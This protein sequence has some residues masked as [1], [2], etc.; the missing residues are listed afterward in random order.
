MLRLAA[1]SG[2][3]SYDCEYVAVAEELGCRLATYDRKVIRRFP[4]IAVTPETLLAELR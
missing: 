1:E 3:S 2:C 4:G